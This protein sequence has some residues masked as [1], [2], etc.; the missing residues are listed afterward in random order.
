MERAQSKAQAMPAAEMRMLQLEQAVAQSPGTACPYPSLQS[1]QGC[2][3]PAAPWAGSWPKQLLWQVAGEDRRTQSLIQEAF[4]SGAMLKLNWVF[5]SHPLEVSG[6]AFLLC[7]MSVYFIAR[8]N[9][10]KYYQTS[11][12]F[13]PPCSVQENPS[14]PTKQAAAYAKPNRAHTD[15]VIFQNDT[16]NLIISEIKSSLSY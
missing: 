13:P 7:I 9:G 6:A 10:N 16:F 1:L 12:A 2:L 15:I 5:R 11:P 14:I 8:K 3:P 4:L